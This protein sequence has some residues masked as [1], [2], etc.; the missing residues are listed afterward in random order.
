MM[1]IPVDWKVFEYKFS[2]NPRAAFEG[3]ATVLFCHEMGISH[4]VFRYFN[5]PYI[6]TQPITAPDGLLTGFQAKY[7]DASTR[8]SSKE[9]DFKNAIADAKQKYSGISRIIFYINKEMSVST[10]P[11]TQKPTYQENIETHGESLGITVEWRGP[12]HIEQMLLALPTIRDLYFNPM[13][14]LSQ[15]V[16]QIQNRSESIRSNIQSEILC[17]S[18]RIK[19][20]HDM[21]KLG[22]LWESEKAVCVIY[23]DAGTGK[24]GA[25]KDLIT[26]RQEQGDEFVCFLFSSTDL[27]VEEESLFLRKYGNYQLEDLLALYSQEKRKVCVIESAEK[28][29]ALNSP[30]VFATLVHKFINHGWKIIFTIRTVYKDSFCNILLKDTSYDEFRV[31]RIS[32]EVLEALSERHH[33]PLPENQNLRHLLRDLFYLK[34]YLKLNPAGLDHLI[35]SEEL[36]LQQVWKEVIC[37]SQ[38]RTE[39]LPVRREEMAKHIVF[40]MLQ[41]ES[42]IYISSANDDYR[43]LTALEDSGIIA[44]YDN[45]PSQWMMSHDVY[46]ELIVKH[47]LTQRY[48]ERVGAEKFLEGFGLSLRA[49]KLYRIW[50]ESIFASVGDRYVDFLITMFQS[51]LDQVWKDETLIALMQSDQVD[52]FRAID[53]ILS[54][55]QYYLFTRMVFLLNTACRDIDRELLKKLSVL[56]GNTYRFTCP[57]GRAWFAVFQYIYNNRVLIP[58]TVQNLDIVANT[59]MTWTKKYETGE[60]TRLA[61]QIALY[62]KSEVWKKEQHPYTL[63]RDSRF[64]ILT[65][66]ILAAAMELKQELTD[67]FQSLTDTKLADGNKENQ[68]LLQKS[69]SNIYECGKVC[70]AIPE[71]V[72]DLAERYW[73]DPSQQEHDYYLHDSMEHYFGLSRSLGMKYEAESA[74]Q[75]P[76][77]F[78]LQEIPVQALNMILRIMNY[79]TDCYNSS[80][81]ATEY[82][83]CS[84]LELHFPDGTVRRQ[85]C[86]DRLWKMYRGTHVAPKLLES[87]LMA[88]EKWLL[89]LAEFTDGKTICQFCEY[90]LRKSKTAAI[91]AVVLSVVSAYPDKLFPISCILLKTKEIFVFDVARLQA[92]HGADFLKGTLASHRWFD[93]ERMDTNALPFRKKQF[94]QVLLDYQIEEGILSENEKEGRKTQLY[95]AFDEAT[96]DIDSW[97]AVYQFAYY[98]SDL[99]RCQI[100]SQTVSQDKVMISVVPDIPENLVALSEQDQRSHEDFM[101]H[102][103]LMLWADAKLRG[104]QDAAQQYPQFE[105]GI[106][107]VVNEIYQILEEEEARSHDIFSAVNACA[108]LLREQR[109][110]MN[111]T[112]LTFCTEVLLATCLNFLDQDRHLVPYKLNGVISAVASLVSSDNL[113]ADWSSPLFVL[114]ALVMCNGKQNEALNS[115]SSILWLSVPD[116]AR[117]LMRAYA[118]LVPQYFSQVLCYN[119]ISTRDFF[120]QNS[121]EIQALFQENVSN[122]EA[123]PLS[124]LE[125]HQLIALQRMIPSGNVEDSFGFVLKI[126]D[127][128]WD[129]LFGSE[130]TDRDRYRDYEGEYAY[131]QWLGD[132]VLDLSAEQQNIFLEHLVKHVKYDKEFTRFLQDVIRAEDI[133]PR[134]S[135]FWGFWDLMKNYIFSAFEQAPRFKQ[136]IDEDWDIRFGIGNVLTNYLLAGPKW[137]EDITTWHSLREDCAVFYKTTINRLG[138]HP[139][140]LYSIGRLLNSIGSQVFFEYAVEWLSD[141]VS[142]N[143]QLRQ[144][145]LPTNTIYYVEEYM[146][147]YVQKRL[148]HLKSDAPRKREVLNVLDFLVDRG[149]SLGFLLRENII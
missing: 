142:N 93:R 125:V 7:Y 5:Q 147:R 17:R 121:Q 76:M 14:G 47:I 111:K 67:I 94:E 54:Q 141:I 75:T 137:K 100:S 108:V 95:A 89:D 70:Q 32:D 83:E 21:Q 120:E 34:L 102:V 126:G 45:S 58:W 135:A 148:Y 103:P 87:V 49:R 73:C 61:G 101:R 79:T 36:F 115:V 62:L 117:K 44:V 69:L 84:Q 29:S 13:P 28:F 92:E 97:E 138:A 8:I 86:S 41:Q 98:Q 9:A 119:G 50:L 48:Q 118:A 109:A 129:T 122:L 80:K 96:R 149:S 82:S 131:T 104:D 51:G 144:I 114:L 139:A 128:V 130:N 91:T 127:R 145:D 43:A 78:L 39:N 99:R 53:P 71:Q 15:W 106:E 2:Q 24:S 85:M 18:E 57:V 37:D 64:I 143:S 132:Y 133:K 123:V 26:Q 90:L 66:V 6:E 60:T 52:C 22:T 59:L 107:P 33:F 65:D 105:G 42:S 88:L 19:I 38:R 68:L 35:S 11:G 20:C 25:V 55:N 56:P 113:T 81:L 63:L 27:D 116:V 10:R 124:G 12:S 134:Y 30:Q 77:F 140:I 31:E 23:G 3:L 16:E 46:E 1:N 110:A 4:G 72:L 74:F 136:Y 146:C 112:T 40:S